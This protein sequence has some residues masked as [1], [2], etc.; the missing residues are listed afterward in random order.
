MSRIS[1]SLPDELIARLEPL[2]E[3]INISQVCRE[4]LERRSDM[5]QRA[6]EHEENDLDLENLTGRLHEE[7]ALVDGK[8]EYLSRRNAAAWLSTTS[9]EE[10]KSVV[11]HPRRSDTKKYKLPRTAFR[12]MKRDMKEANGG[13]EGTPAVMYKTAWLDYVRAVLDRIKSEVEA[14][15]GTQPIDAT[16]DAGSTR[17]AKSKRVEA[18]K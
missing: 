4:A 8:W 10:L 18:T 1:I 9:Y 15:Q 2:K 17:P 16:E 12:M 3:R 7:R 11:E 14:G 13:T 6:A 5:L